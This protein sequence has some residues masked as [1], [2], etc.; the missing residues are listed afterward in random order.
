MANIGGIEILMKKLACDQKGFTLIEIITVL[1][2]LGVTAA[3]AI[4]KYL[5]IGKPW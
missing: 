3:T 2:I 5:D 4:P 1:V